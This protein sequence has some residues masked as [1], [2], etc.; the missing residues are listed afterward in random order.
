M[1]NSATPAKFNRQVNGRYVK[2]KFTD[3]EDALLIQL[4]NEHG[5]L[6]WSKIAMLMQTRN[7]RQCRERYNNYLKPDLR[8]DA[9][10]PEEDALLLAKFNEHGAKWNTIAQ[11]FINRSDLSLRN[12]WQ[13]LERQKVKSAV[14]TPTTPLLIETPSEPAPD[15]AIV[16]NLPE[17]PLNPFGFND[18]YDLHFGMTE[19]DPFNAWSMFSF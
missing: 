10:T 1:N 18:M 2:V 11:F 8:Q 4:V 12:R 3:E 15:V 5:T 13:R 16:A 6:D 17:P 9:W 19:S 14:T 7:V